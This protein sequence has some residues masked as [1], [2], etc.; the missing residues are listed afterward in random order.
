MKI[1]FCQHCKE[2][3]DDKKFYLGKCY[4]S[5]CYQLI[6]KL[7]SCSVCNQTKH[8]L[9]TLDIPVCNECQFIGIPCIKCLR[10]EIKLGSVTTDGP[11]CTSCSKYILEQKIC[12]WCGKKKSD[13]SNRKLNNE[14][15]FICGSCYTNT[16]PSCSICKY[17]RKPLIYDFNK[18]PICNLCA[19]EIKRNCKK[20]G[21]EIDAG[22]GHFCETC[23]YTKTLSKRVQLGQTELSGHF[24]ALFAMF[25]EWL[26]VRRGLHFSAS[27]IRTYFP[28]FL[29]IDRLALEIGRVPTYLE[30]VE[31]FT[32][33]V[34]RKNL[35]VTVFLDESKIISVDQS[36]KND[37]SN[38]DSIERYLCKFD[39][40]S[41]HYLS[42]AAYY[43]SLSI[44]QKSGKTSF[45]S[46]RL[47]MTPAAKLINLCIH[48]GVD[49]PNNEILYGLLW[50]SSGQRAAITGFVNF[51]NHHYQMNLTIAPREE[52]A[53]NRPKESTLQNKQRLITLLRNPND[54]EE[55]KNVLIVVS[56]AYL[57]RISVPK[58]A[59][60]SVSMLKKNK[61]GDYYLRLAG[62]D[63]YLPFRC[64]QSLLS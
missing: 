53:I 47:A 23:S 48:F 31:K 28:Y 37:Y 44:K 41:F 6:F 33:A 60:V 10:T 38:L 52:I 42:L 4:C 18:K 51:L 7:N 58:L 1:F 46:I 5:S 3:T 50:V 43:K 19:L 24:S 16:L 35:L 40:S 17:K 26:T 49:K 29:S 21:T 32:V 9:N 27:N 57:H 54:T 34:T 36:T 62:Q 13:I 12:D 45:R 14:I 30:I 22:S 63:F 61:G 2:I 11:I 56:L 55:Y 20:C 25:G 39:K 59:W 8:I 64:V 15:A